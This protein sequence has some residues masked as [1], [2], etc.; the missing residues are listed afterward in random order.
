MLGIVNK[1]EQVNVRVKPDL[2]ADLE[3]LAE[4]H[5]LT[6]SSYVHS[7]LTRHVRRERE[8]EP[9]IFKIRQP[10]LAPVAA[11]ISPS[12]EVLMRKEIAAQLSVPI[13]KKKVK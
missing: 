3:I 11:R 1:N 5:G 12:E 2:K 9:D 8:A 10:A 7:I 13:L 6:V 4:F